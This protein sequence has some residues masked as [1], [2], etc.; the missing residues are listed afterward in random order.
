MADRTLQIRRLK[1]F[2]A[3]HGIRL[4]QIAQRA[5]S[6]RSRQTIYSQ[7]ANGKISAGRLKKLELAAQEL[8]KEN[9]TLKKDIYEL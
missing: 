3:A 8:A 9:G 7:L 6:N 5:Y 2:A 4:Y 1:A